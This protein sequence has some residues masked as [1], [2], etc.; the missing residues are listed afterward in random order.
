M[1]TYPSKSYFEVI[2]EKGHNKKQPWEKYDSR[3]T[4]PYT[5]T[6]C[7]DKIPAHSFHSHLERM[8]KKVIKK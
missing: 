6:L 8:D 3:T 7:G 5:C 4:V 1:P 2:S